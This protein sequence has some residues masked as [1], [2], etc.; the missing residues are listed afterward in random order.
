MAATE[1]IRSYLPNHD[2][3]TD[4][5]IKQEDVPLLKIHNDGRVNR[6]LATQ[7][8]IGHTAFGAVLK[9]VHYGIYQDE[10]ACL[11]SLEFSF[12][13]KS[14]S[15]SR[16]CYAEID[17]EFEKAVDVRKPKIRST[18]PDSDP[19]VVNFAPKEVYGIVKTVNEKKYGDVS[20]PLMFQTPVGLSAG[21]MGTFGAEKKMIEENRMEIHG[22][23]AQDDDHDEGANAVTW[24]L[25]EN[26]TSKDGILRSFRAAIV[27][28]YGRGEA[29][30]MRVSVKPAIKFSL[31]PRRIST[32]GDS[33]HRLLQRN[34]DPILL[35]GVTPLKGQPDLACDDFS[36]SEFPWEKILQFPKEYEVS[37]LL[38][39]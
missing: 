13:F 29:F 33:L 38:P 24:D 27:V 23:L 26:A 30:W 5:D 11:I 25:T 7:D 35:D 21:I 1:D 34:D 16:Y 8:H 15:H 36:S 37:D 2:F 14:K 18:D 4:L 12:K 20:I 19:Q 10:P 39:A 3:E 28:K 32:K 9:R 6:P 22:N 31:D 17:V